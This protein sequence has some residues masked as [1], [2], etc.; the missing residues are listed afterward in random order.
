M[1]HKRQQV[2]G[3]GTGML[4]GMPPEDFHIVAD[5][6]IYVLE[7][8]D[9]TYHSYHNAFSTSKPVIQVLASLGIKEGMDYML[10]IIFN[11]TSKWGFRYRMVMEN[12][13]LY[14]GN[15]KPYIPKFEAHKDINKPGDRFT[16]RWQEMVKA[17]QEDENPRKLTTLEEVRQLGNAA[18]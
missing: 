13:P 16:A 3:C 8:K 15:A 2:R 10:D 9:P 18:D 6:M 17:I 4:V 11:D 5:K 7:N 14:G 1:E 12:L